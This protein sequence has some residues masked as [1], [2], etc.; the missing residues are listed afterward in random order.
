MTFAQW[1][2]L[3]YA[4]CFIGWIWE[5]CYVSVR[6]GK[7]CNRGFL[8]GPFLPIYG[9]GAIVILLSTFGVR[10]NLWLVYVIGMISSTIL[11]YFTGDAMQRMFGV[12]YWDYSKHRFNLK[13]HIC[14]GVSL[15]W[16]LFS[17]LLVRF[18]NPPV[19]DLVTALPYRLTEILTYGLTVVLAVD[20]TVSV[21]EALDLKKLLKE[22]A[23]G[24]ETIQKVQRRADFVYAMA[25]DDLKRRRLKEMAEGSETIQKVQRR[26]DFVYAMAEDDLKRRRRELDEKV[27]DAKSKAGA[28][29][30][31]LSKRGALKNARFVKILK[32]NP[33]AVSARLK[34]ELEELKLQLD[35]YM[36]YGE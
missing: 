33:G 16:G 13:G 8:H 24:S 12:R 34:D 30:E 14:L 29:L 31:E 4:Y 7:F 1:V 23:E 6:A 25:E 27:S 32:R 22:M 17:V 11:E 36:K 35:N 3:F 19:M 10:D 9:S 18:V 2:L 26:A 28:V 20:T 5:T 21:Y 15:G